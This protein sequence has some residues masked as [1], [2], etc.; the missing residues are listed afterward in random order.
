MNGCKEGWKENGM[1]K[2]E[3]RWEGR[4]DVRNSRITLEINIRI[5]EI[6]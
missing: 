5:Y 6:F 1:C 4:G 3:G 2:N